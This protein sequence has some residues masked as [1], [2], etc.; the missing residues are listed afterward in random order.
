MPEPAFD[1]HTKIICTLGPASSDRAVLRDM[2]L[3]GMDIARINMSHGTHDEHRAIIRMVRVLAAE[4]N[5]AVGIMAD[6]QGPK[7]RIGVVREGGVLLREG[8]ILT[9]DLT[10]QIGTETRIPVQSADFFRLIRPG[11]TI[12]VDDGLVE[13]TILAAESTCAAAQVVHGGLLQDR[14]GINILDSRTDVSPLTAKDQEDLAFVL[15]QEVDWIALSFVQSPDNIQEVKELIRQLLPPEAIQVPV[16]AKIEKPKA[17]EVIADIMLLADGLMVARGDLGI[18][19]RTEMVPLIQKDLIH[20]CNTL[21]KPVITATQMLESMIQNPRPTRAEATDVANAVIDGTDGIMLSAETAIGRHPVLAIQ[22]MATIVR[23]AEERFPRQ[24][25]NMESYA[26]DANP[27]AVAVAESVVNVASAVGAK[28]ILAPTA[29]GFTARML[30]SFHPNVPIMAL[31][32]RQKVLQ[33]LSLYRAVHGLATEDRETAEEV[34]QEAI[35][36]GLETGVITEGDKV[37][38]TAG[39]VIGIAG[40]TN[41]M[42]VRRVIKPLLTGRGVGL[43]RILGRCLRCQGETWPEASPELEDAILVVPR[44]TPSCSA[45][46]SACAGIITSDGRSAVEPHLAQAHRRGFAAIYEAQGDYGQLQDGQLLILDAVSGR[47][48]DYK[49]HSLI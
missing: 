4:L 10:E 25:P 43:T 21:G 11:D 16:V 27:I 17:L 42:T 9:F 35:D 33:Q 5:R 30:A 7:L 46:A 14:K 49:Q 38:I 37:V 40:M 45:V 19:A 15:A 29:S 44:F 18:E 12:V 26:L 1:R 24:Y 34:I 28:A 6:L 31:S 41:M 2:I 48:F 32:P 20:R 3:A 36:R 39:T 13:F 8:D 47:V 22:T 23:A